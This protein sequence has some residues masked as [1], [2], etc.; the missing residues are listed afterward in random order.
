MEC[1]ICTRELFGRHE[2]DHFPVPKSLGGKITATICVTCHD[3]KDRIPL[4]KWDPEYA[5]S[6][7][8]GLWG[9]ADTRERMVLAKM[10]HIA[11]Q[12]LAWARGDDADL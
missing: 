4:A 11:S 5:H 12:G 8:V 6:A 10:F 3:Q 9:K 2:R 1:Y 7:L